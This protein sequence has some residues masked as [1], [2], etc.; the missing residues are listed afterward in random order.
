MLQPYPW[1]GFRSLGAQGFFFGIP[2][3]PSGQP[4]PEDSMTVPFLVW[5]LALGLGL[6]LAGGSRAPEHPIDLNRAS[7]TELM[8]LPRVGRRTAERILAFRKQHGGFRRPEEL[9]LV[10]GIGEKA[11]QR[12]RPHLCVTDAAGDG[13]GR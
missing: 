4:V 9:L 3:D 12:L 8:Q 11:F 5:L 13:D 2:F 1:T 7:A 10:K 6:P